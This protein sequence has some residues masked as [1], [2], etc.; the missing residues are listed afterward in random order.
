MAQEAAVT[1]SSLAL[2]CTLAL[3]V[4]VRDTILPAADPTTP[5]GMYQ[6]E[7]SKGEDANIEVLE[8]LATQA[9]SE[10]MILHCENGITHT[11]SEPSVQS[12]TSPGAPSSNQYLQ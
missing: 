12:M 3:P 10:Y 6:T 7:C 5:A 2:V 1:L 4:P 8:S 9:R 11:R